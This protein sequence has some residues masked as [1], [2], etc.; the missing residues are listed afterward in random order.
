[1]GN[2]RQ[3][4]DGAETTYF[5][6]RGTHSSLGVTVVPGGKAEI[7]IDYLDITGAVESIAIVP[8]L[9]EVP[10]QPWTPDIKYT[11]GYRITLTLVADLSHPA[12][13]PR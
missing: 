13:P 6:L 3:D 7:D 8:V 4:A 1:M 5:S 9:E 12:A 10:A 2:K 11:H